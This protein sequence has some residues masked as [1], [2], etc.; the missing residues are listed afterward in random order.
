MATDRKRDSDSREKQIPSEPPGRNTGPGGAGCE[1]R[2]PMETGPDLPPDTEVLEDGATLGRT[3]TATKEQEARIRDLE[4]SNRGMAL[5]L[6]ILNFVQGAD[7]LETT[8]RIILT[9]VTSGYSIGFN[10]AFL[11]LLSGDGKHLRGALA[12]GP[13]SAQEAS[14]IWK[15]IEEK[16]SNLE[17]VVAAAR[18]GGREGDVELTRLARHME[19][20]V[21]E[22]ASMLEEC[23]L[24]GETRV[25][26]DK[27]MPEQGE[28]LRR[29]GS[30]V[31]VCTP[32]TSAGKA[33]G[34]II[35]DNLI[36]GEMPSD[37]QVGLLRALAYQ[38]G[39][40]IATASHHEDIERRLQELSTL[41][42][43]SKGILSTTDL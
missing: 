9:C 5:L 26:R 38:V 32:I 8:L 34:V 36:T 18:V 20:R 27:D 28:I 35:A 6:E 23:I 1:E 11:F 13:R 41:T 16:A 43:V 37:E 29:L 31:F 15:D 24:R 19:I 21:G 17:D 30:G 33:I 10:R 14:E 2:P 25:V 40:I 3:A 12:V 39:Q 7:D 4:R 22:G 42:E